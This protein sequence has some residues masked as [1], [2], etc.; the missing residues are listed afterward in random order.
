MG[1]ENTQPEGPFK[2]EDLV[3]LKHAGALQ[4]LLG[5]LH[6]DH[7]HPNRILHYDQYLSLLLLYFFNPVVTSLRG[8]QFASQL[9]RVQKQ[10]GVERASLGSL[11]EAAQVFD[12]DL[13][14]GVF[15]SLAAQA[16]ALDAPAPLTGLPEGLAITAVEGSLLDALPKMLW[17]LWLGPSE[18]AVKL[19]LQLEVTRGVPVQAEV[20]E[21]N[22]NEREVLKEHL[23]A[24]CVYLLDRGYVDY[25]LYSAILQAG[26]SFVARLRGAA[27][28]EVLETRPLTADAR[29]AGVEVDQ[30]VWLGGEKS[31]RRIPQ[32]LRI[33]KIH[34]KNQAAQGL[35][36]RLARVNHKELFFRWFKC[37][38]GCKH[39]LAESENGV[40]IELYAA[41]IASLL[42]VLWTG[43]KPTKR[44]LEMLQYGFV[45]M[46][47][48]AEVEAHIAGLKM[49]K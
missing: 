32:P 48:L 1:A 14:K 5:R 9:E 45:G 41:L 7:A 43:R 34:V 33:L 26:S 15:E 46:A 25:D 6:Q 3:A 31:G 37:V 47:S 39:L 21:G 42:I 40:R 30:I 27:D 12:P 16:C 13:A 28:Y 19:H 35:K 10:L 2:A 29:A 44:T 20:T 22:G 36:P 49:V 17:A 18:H 4:G 8:I 11:S 23:R 38:L 24:G